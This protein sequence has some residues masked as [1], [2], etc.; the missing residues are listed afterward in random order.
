MKV[1]LSLAC[2]GLTAAANIATVH[3]DSVHAALYQATHDE[4]YLTEAKRIANAAIS[5]L[6]SSNGIL[7]EPCA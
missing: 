6:V 3:G 1:L 7:M 2:A 5:T 4:T